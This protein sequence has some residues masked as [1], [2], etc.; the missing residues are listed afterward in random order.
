[1]TPESDHPRLKELPWSAEAEQ[2]AIGAVMLVESMWSEVSWLPPNAFFRP[3]HRLLWE[4]IRDLVADNHPI[5][6]LT[7]NEAV[8]DR[9]WQEKVPEAMIAEIAETTP[10]A[11]NA[12]AYADRVH[13]YYARRLRIALSND[14]AEASYANDI[15]GMATT[16]AA[17]AAG[18]YGLVSDYDLGVYFNELPDPE[19]IQWAVDELFYRGGV[20]CFVGPPKAGKTAAARTLAA[21]ISSG[22]DYTFLG[23]DCKGGT[24][25]Y[26]DYENPKTVTQNEL[27]RLRN[28]GLSLE[29]LV[30]LLSQVKPQD[31]EHATAHMHALLTAYRPLLLI[32]DGLQGW[33]GI[34]D[35][36]TTR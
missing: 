13:G 18:D 21:S 10:A 17:I 30:V 24:A 31:L 33:A 28:G 4:V 23:R 20:Y 26:V 29:G 36:S 32:I 8:R 6:P 15:N 22:I 35:L 34:K 3:A 12:R 16:Q 1:M 11:T 19:P 2:S 7:V 9:G 5:D 14:Y 25:I 27:A